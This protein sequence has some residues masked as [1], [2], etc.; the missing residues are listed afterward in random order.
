M[1]LSEVFAGIFCGLGIMARMTE[2][3]ASAI[4][5]LAI[6]TLIGAAVA[7]MLFAADVWVDSVKKEATEA[8]DRR[9]RA[10]REAERRRVSRPRT[11]PYRRQLD[12]YL[13]EQARLK[14]EQKR[15]KPIRKLTGALAEDFTQ[16]PED[17]RRGFFSEV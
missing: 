5:S 2:L 13:A 11:E 9:R 16:L 14:S 7:F 4:V 15:N 17:E 6:G 8:E 3:G 10:Q 1:K 12:I